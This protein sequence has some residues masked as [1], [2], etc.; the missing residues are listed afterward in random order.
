MVELGVEWDAEGI[1]ER[2]LFRLREPL[3]SFF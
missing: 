2:V 3:A 1:K